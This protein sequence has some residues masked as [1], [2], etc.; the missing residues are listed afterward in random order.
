[1]DVGAPVAITMSLDKKLMI[2]QMGTGKGKDSLLLIYDPANG[3]PLAK[4]ETG[5]YDISGLAYHPKSKKLY[6][7]DFAWEAPKEGG[8]FRLDVTGE[9]EN[10]K[11]KTER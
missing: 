6:A 11:V 2:G 7:V 3:K 9:G 5:L 1:K 4:M 8:L 10:A